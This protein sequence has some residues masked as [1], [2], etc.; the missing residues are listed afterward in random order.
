M[1][2]AFSSFIYSLTASHLFLERLVFSCFDYNPFI[3]KQLQTFFCFSRY[4]YGCLHNLYI[5]DIWDDDYFFIPYLCYCLKCLLLMNFLAVL[6]FLNYSL[7]SK[8]PLQCLHYPTFKILNFD[9]S[10]Y[11]LLLSS[12]IL[13]S[14]YLMDHYHESCSNAHFAYFLLSFIFFTSVPFFISVI[15]V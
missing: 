6:H 10:S 7:K 1:I 3:L 12:I 9:S 14:F 13:L 8:I 2:I 5:T 4:G 15:A 11:E